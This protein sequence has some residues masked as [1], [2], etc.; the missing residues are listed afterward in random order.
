MV[1]GGQL[2]PETCPSSCHLP[3]VSQHLCRVSP[4]PAEALCA[5]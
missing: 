5:S 1:A 3:G 4:V 2:V